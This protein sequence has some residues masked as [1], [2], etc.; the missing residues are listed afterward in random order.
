MATLEYLQKQLQREYYSVTLNDEDDLI[1]DD[2]ANRSPI[3]ITDDDPFDEKLASHSE[4]KMLFDKVISNYHK[5]N[6]SSMSFSSLQEILFHQLHL[7]G[8]L[9]DDAIDGT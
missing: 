1:E 4:H 6:V 8:N 3:Y 2:L 5:S 9:Y 7:S